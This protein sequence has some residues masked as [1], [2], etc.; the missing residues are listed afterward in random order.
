MTNSNK[1]INAHITF[2]N[3]EASPAL[4]QY[5]LDKIGGCVQKFIHQDSEI[6]IILKVEKNRQIAE[7]FFHSDGSD[8]SATEESESLYA[9]IDILVDTIGTRLRKHKEKM[10]KHH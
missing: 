1:S 5:A 4:K 2:K 9:A 10:L 8:F 3:T 7:V 6:K